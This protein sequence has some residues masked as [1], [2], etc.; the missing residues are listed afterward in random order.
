MKQYQSRYIKLCS[1]KYAYSCTAQQSALDQVPSSHGDAHLALFEAWR[2]WDLE[3]TFLEVGVVVLSGGVELFDVVFFENVF[4]H[5]LAV[6]DHLQVFVLVLSFKSELLATGDAVSHLQQLLGDFWNR[7]GFTFLD[8]SRIMSSVL[9][10]PL[11][12]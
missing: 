6:D 7:E 8:L 12:W 2:S 3:Q 4:D 10:G 5:V 1:R 11:A 9:L